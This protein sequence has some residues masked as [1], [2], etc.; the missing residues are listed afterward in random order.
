MKI[1][2]FIS[3]LLFF[4]GFSAQSLRN[5][6]PQSQPSEDPES[7]ISKFG[8]VDTL[9]NILVPYE[10]DSYDYLED[11]YI[12]EKNGKKA[13]FDEYGKMLLP[14]EYLY[15]TINTN[16]SYSGL[17]LSQFVIFEDSTS[18]KGILNPKLNKK[19]KCIYKGI[20]QTDLSGEYFFLVTYIAESSGSEQTGIVDGECNELL[21]P[22]YDKIELSSEVSHYLYHNDRL[23]LV[24]KNDDYP[25][26]A[27]IP[28]NE[29]INYR[30]QGVYNID[31]KQW[32]IK[33]DHISIEIQYNL[34]KIWKDF[35][36]AV[37]SP[38]EAFNY[39]F[40]E[41]LQYY[42]NSVFAN[43]V[44][45][46]LDKSYVYSFK[47]GISGPFED[48]A[49]SGTSFGFIP[50]KN[51]GK[52]GLL[53][54][55]EGK[56]NI[57]CVYDNC[58]SLSERDLNFA[59]KLILAYAEKEGA[60][61]YLDTLGRQF[62]LNFDGEVMKS[63]GKYGYGVYSQN[64]N[65]Q[66]FEIVP[67]IYEKVEPFMADYYDT[68][69]LMVKKDG[70]YGIINTRND[71]FIPVNHSKLER[72][73]DGMERPVLK[74]TRGDVS[75]FY[76]LDSNF[77]VE[78]DYKSYYYHEGSYD[79]YLVF[80]T[81]KNKVGMWT[82]G[83]KKIIEPIY[84]EFDYYDYETYEG[85]SFV[86]S[87]NDGKTGLISMKGRIV[88]NPEYQDIYTVEAGDYGSTYYG[89][90][91]DG[92]YGMT[93][94]NGK[95]ILPIEYDNL[96]DYPAPWYPIP[97]NGKYGYLNDSLQLE[98]PCQYD[99]ADPFDSDTLA[100][101]QYQG[102]Y[103]VIDRKAKFIIKPEY[104]DLLYWMGD[105][106]FAKMGGLWGLLDI[107]GK[108]LFEP[109]YSDKGFY[110]SGNN[111]IYLMKKNGKWG[112]FDYI[113]LKEY[114]AF[115]YDKIS[116]NNGNPY[117]LAVRDKKYG[118]LNN[119]GQEIIP[120]EYEDISGYINNNLIYAKKEGKYGFINI[121]NETIIGF[122]FDDAE[123]FYYGHASVCKNKKWAIADT[124][125][126]VLT[127]YEYDEIKYI[128]NDNTVM[129]VTGKKYG[130]VSNTGEIIVPFEY[131]YLESREKDYY[132]KKG[133]EE[134]G[135]L[136]KK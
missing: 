44:F 105:R 77:T 86:L 45:Y 81:S 9:G 6:Y 91:K 134:T 32:L 47:G 2:I 112:L 42:D 111:T 129:A 78:G 66:L 31:K 60:V 132:F 67:C 83:G 29:I 113:Q 3:L 90:K 76:F 39:K 58:L 101:V 136:P 130:V 71:V 119:E 56:L 41:S 4:S 14:C 35:K 62:Y 50:V 79:M 116:T 27:M 55:S 94:K 123:N 97:K 87:R 133:K 82:Q 63:G 24:E 127:P 109:V 61:Y 135:Y 21:N 69:L 65:E 17:F 122:E 125:G 114:G 99:Y 75:G 16:Y 72:L 1:F 121:K 18:R 52:W 88:F 128:Y 8:L 108:W 107:N 68:D 15:I 103:G 46:I 59:G 89:V 19:T 106:I 26:D 96:G 54:L 40:S 102:K 12:L 10:Y 34:I 11:Y 49:V 53:S 43:D 126:K 117:A 92:K 5:S 37:F 57:P 23:A 84:D 100:V 38:F 51:N 28:D 124:T 30:K 74:Y 70:K 118:Y 93:D 115:I 33:P 73:F 48:I 13:L 98:I 120:C 85:E 7:E 64:E 25:C 131:D 95:I 104:E 36:F 80:K 110:W 22:E 20:N